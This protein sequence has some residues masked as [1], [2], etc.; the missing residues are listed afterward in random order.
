MSV[1]KLVDSTQLNSDLTSVANAIRTKGGTSAQLAFPADFVSAI[2]AIPSGGGGSGLSVA[3]FSATPA[4]T[5]STISFDVG[6]YTLPAIYVM[7]LK[8]NVTAGDGAHIIIRNGMWDNQSTVPVV[9]RYY[10]YKVNGASDYYSNNAQLT[11]NGSTLSLYYNT[12]HYFLSGATYSI[13]IYELD[14][15]FFS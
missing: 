15:S 4:S 9:R 2:S 11:K 10:V 1:D 5:A 12:N 6:D 13:Q 8:S 3:T 14:S 7:Y